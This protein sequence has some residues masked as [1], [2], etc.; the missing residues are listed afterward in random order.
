MQHFSGRLLFEELKIDKFELF[1][2]LGL[3]VSSASATRKVLL[4]QLGR[5]LPNDIDSLPD[6]V[7]LANTSDYYGARM[8]EKLSDNGGFKVVCAAN[9]AEVR[10]SLTC[11]VVKIQVGVLFLEIGGAI[12]HLIAVNNLVTKAR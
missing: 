7:F 2:S 1:S 8:A 11:L 12:C 4:E 9:P 3:D 5:V 6:K 10:A